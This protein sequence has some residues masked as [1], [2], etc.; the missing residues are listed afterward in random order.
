MITVVVQKALNP[1]KR[2][3]GFTLPELLLAAMIMAIAFVALLG[4]YVTCLEL[5]ELASNTARAT[6]ACQSKMEEIITTDSAQIPGLFDRV[7]FDTPGLDGR[8]VSYIEVLS[9]EQPG[10]PKRL[11]ATVSVSWRQRRGRIIGEDTNLNGQIDAGEDINPANNM[12]DS[13]V[14]LTTQILKR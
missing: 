6:A 4:S 12:L 13:P 5:N 1:A 14:Q 8:G 10:V 2:Y 11:N 9:W 7:A 3:R